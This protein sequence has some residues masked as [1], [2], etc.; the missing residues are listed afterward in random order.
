MLARRRAPPMPE[1]S[2]RN[3]FAGPY[4]DRVSGLRRDEAWLAAALADPATRYIPVWRSHSLVRHEPAPAAVLVARAALAA[5]SAEELILLG[6]F[7]GA[8]CFAIELVADAPPALD[9]AA[10]FTDLRLAGGLLP[11]DEAGLLA[12]A[13]AMVY[14]R[15]RHRYC[16]VCGAPC[17]AASSGH[18]MACTRETCG[19]EFFPRIDPA[20]I[21]L[22]TDGERALL[23]RQASWPPGRY[24]TIAG[25]VEPGESLEDAVIREVREETSVEV[26]AVEYHSSQPWPFPSSLMV[27]FRARAGASAV[28]CPDGELEDA[29]WFTTGELASG[30]PALPLPQS[31]S[32]R[33]IADWYEDA[34]G[35][36]LAAEPGARLWTQK[37]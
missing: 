13:R 4:V 36:S 7:R 26:T 28:A 27:G 37:R 19:T 35:R 24:S 30:T 3:V 32:F 12:Y 1:P 14:W 18:V 10:V 34:T 6:R 9:P 20:I 23:G 25:F 11:P 31:I 16:G 21:V 17:R 29:R 5:V 2:A 22:V 8:A 15:E 33:L